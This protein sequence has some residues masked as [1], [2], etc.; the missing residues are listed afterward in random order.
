MTE[1]MNPATPANSQPNP[2][3][4][5]T[6][7]PGYAPA[8]GPSYPPPPAAPM[9]VYQPRPPKPKEPV[10]RKDR[11]FALLFF[12]FSILWVDFAL[13]GGFRLGFAL[14][15]PLFALLMTAY[16]MG[17]EARVSFYPLACGL[18]AAAG[19]IPFALYQDTPVQLVSFGAIVALFALCGGQLAGCLKHSPGGFRCAADVL[20]SVF[21]YPFEYMG[22]TLRSLFSKTPG[23][24]LKHKNALG[25]I[26]IG[27]LCAVPALAI[28]IPLLIRS[29]LY[30]EQLLSHL[31]FDAPKLAGRLILGALL[32]LLL[33]A[34]LFAW[35]KKLPCRTARTG[36][37]AGGRIDPVIIQAFL[38]ALSLVY[39]VYLLTQ[40]AY[41]F[42]AFAGL[43]PQ[44]YAQTACD[45][46]RRGFFEMCAIASIN[47]GILFL[48]M[49]L[50]RK[51]EGR[52]PLVTKFLGS[53]LC[54]FT[55]VLI[56]T[57]LSKMFLYIDNSGMTRRRMM[58]SCFMVF[59]ALV[60]IAA[61][62]RLWVRRFAYMKAVV[63]AFCL[64][65]LTV[66][67][68]D[69][70]ATVARYNVAAYRS[71]ALEQL[72][73]E[74]LAGLSDSAVPYLLELLDDSD[75][76]VARQAHNE[77]VHK[78]FGHFIVDCDCISSSC[79][80]DYETRYEWAAS[81]GERYRWLNAGCPVPE[82]CEFPPRLEPRRAP[83]DW[84]RYN[85]ASQQAER[86]LSEN[87]ERI[88]T[89]QD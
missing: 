56:G 80:C 37:T 84:R 67:Y 85:R 35:K 75:P 77:L 64:V 11:V 30:F 12:V 66:S 51:Q 31:S 78:V 73:V 22:V 25:K 59:L 40:T 50:V 20:Q 28:V 46:A 2:P 55:I 29:D 5:E 44:G 36:D 19:S 1:P 4:P 33:F 16:L 9:P 82:Q 17:R 24:E 63:L 65:G 68:C 48:S 23:A 6:F 88:L 52:I 69:I 43:L 86:L 39:L 38:S 21:V 49:V 15:T 79:S 62:I 7:Q 8:P 41:F 72:D 53:F 26:V 42:S 47:L 18:L 13:F 32:F 3:P 10:G 81:D 76:E 61:A 34:L 83:G 58:T 60:F 87:A 70:D 27:L 14:V 57:A 45:Y 74:T 89:V 71:G 54:L